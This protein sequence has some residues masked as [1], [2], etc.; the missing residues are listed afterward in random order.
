MTED[1]P[2]RRGPRATAPADARAGRVLRA[3]RME[4]GMTQPQLGAELGVSHVQIGKYEAGRNGMRVSTVE[5]AA[6]L[7][8]VPPGTFFREPRKR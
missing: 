5:R 2:T 8:G 4:R 6:T 3:L 1:E 7:F